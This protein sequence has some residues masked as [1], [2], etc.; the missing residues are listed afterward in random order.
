MTQ[1]KITTFIAVKMAFSF[2]TERVPV[3]Y[4]EHRESTQCVPHILPVYVY[5]L[6]NF[7]QEIQLCSPFTRLK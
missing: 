7:L 2:H 4:S 6:N 3:E 5:V 1:T